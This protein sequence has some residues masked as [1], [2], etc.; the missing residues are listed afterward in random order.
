MSH[1]IAPSIGPL[2]VVQ[3]DPVNA[4]LTVYPEVLYFLHP[5]MHAFAMQL[6]EKTAVRHLQIMQCDTEV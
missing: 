1:S 3:L 2:Q 5:H 6:C 4:Y